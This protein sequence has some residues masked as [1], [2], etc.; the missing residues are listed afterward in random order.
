MIGRLILA[1]VVAMAV[2]LGINA[3]RHPEPLPTTTVTGVTTPVGMCPTEDSCTAD[4]HDGH[5]TIT[6]TTP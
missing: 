3:H 4:Y 6:R 1:T 5:W 2:A